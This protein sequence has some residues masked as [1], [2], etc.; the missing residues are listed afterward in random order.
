MVPLKLTTQS[1]RK[2]I[3]KIEVQID[4]QSCSCK[5]YWSGVRVCPPCMNCEIDA[6]SDLELHLRLHDF[7]SIFDPLGTTVVASA[8]PSLI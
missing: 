6:D 1:D 7:E 2:T 5:I 4:E 8:K 3:F